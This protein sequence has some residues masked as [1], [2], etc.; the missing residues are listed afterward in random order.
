MAN[1]MLLARI[2]LDPKVMTGQP[3][4]KGTRL[5]VQFIL[6]SLAQ[7]ATMES[8]LEEYS[9]LSREDI[10][11]CLEYASKTLEDTTFMPMA[12]EAA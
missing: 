2:I 3:V 5:T 4:I 11:A 9:S 1:G 8:L 10:L 7:G 6:R 12:A